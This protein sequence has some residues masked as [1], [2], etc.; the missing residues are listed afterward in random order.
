MNMK[1]KLYVALTRTKQILFDALT[2]RIVPGLGTLIGI[3]IAMVG[4]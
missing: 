3:D 1:I 2:G 4:T